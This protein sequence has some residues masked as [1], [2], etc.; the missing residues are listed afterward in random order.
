M[1]QTFHSVIRTGEFVILNHFWGLCSPAS[2]MTHMPAVEIYEDLKMGLGLKCTA[3]CNKP[4]GYHSFLLCFKYVW[5]RSRLYVG[6]R[7]EWFVVVCTTG[8]CSSR[9]MKLVLKE[10]LRQC[11]LLPNNLS[12]FCLLFLTERSFVRSFCFCLMSSD[13][14]SILGTIY[15]V[16]LFWIYHS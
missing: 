2:V 9:Q 1:S 6:L 7:S 3:S 13:A 4:P 8:Q 11:P 5:Y 15:K 14:K 16:S 12:C 10:S